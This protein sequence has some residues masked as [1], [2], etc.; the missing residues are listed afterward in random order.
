MQRVTRYPMLVERLEQL[1]DPQNPDAAHI[2]MAFVEVQPRTG[3]LSVQLFASY[4]HI[5]GAHVTHAAEKGYKAHK[6]VHQRAG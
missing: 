3:A 6:L 5:N 1:T 4:S 2:K